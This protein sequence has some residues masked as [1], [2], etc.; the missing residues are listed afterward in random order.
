MYHNIYNY[1]T[2]LQKDMKRK[3]LYN[4]VSWPIQKQTK[5][6]YTKKL[7]EYEKQTNKTKEDKKHTDQKEATNNT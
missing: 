5:K 2:K 6:E 7:I 3:K 1:T 4:C